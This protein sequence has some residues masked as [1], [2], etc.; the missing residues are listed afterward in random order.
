MVEMVV[1]MVVMMVVVVM[2]PG[3]L[4]EVVPVSLYW[5]WRARLDL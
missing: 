1:E 5:W 3:I 4:L 2:L